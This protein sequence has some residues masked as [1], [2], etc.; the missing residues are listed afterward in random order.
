MVL[1][2]SFINHSNP[3]SFVNSLR[4]KRFRRIREIIE[5][6]IA[7]RGSVKVLDIGGEIAYWRN[8]GWQNNAATI[9]LLNL[10]P[11]DYKE[12][13]EGYI[14]VQG[15]ALKL[16]Y[17]MGEFDLVFSNS[18]IEHVGSEANQKIFANEVRRISCNY[19]IQTP[20][21]WFPLEPH[22]MIPFFQF[23]PH[24]IRAVLIMVFNINYFPK[25]KSYQEA[26]KVS[27]NTLMLTRSGFQKLFP[28]AAIEVEYLY[29]I[30]K[31][32]SV[33]WINK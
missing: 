25:T 15:N 19:I 8:M 11:V 9:Y 13:Q 7:E 31:S 6:L 5:E 14:Q 24:S 17:E 16:P 29:G 12:Q 1:F 20:S 26:I 3:D 27:K 23:I 28:E 21:F 4:K 33:Y 32:Y 30:P 18:V 22:S 10:D 2:N